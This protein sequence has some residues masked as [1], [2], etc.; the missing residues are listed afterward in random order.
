MM[1]VT[2][3]D[4]DDINGDGDDV[5]VDLNVSL[6]HPFSILCRGNLCFV[7]RIKA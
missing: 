3:L 4:N 6:L 1:M 5:V 2:I 7:F